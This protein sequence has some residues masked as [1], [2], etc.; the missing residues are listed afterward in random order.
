MLKPKVLRSGEKSEWE[1]LSSSLNTPPT[2]SLFEFIARCQHYNIPTRFLDFTTKFNIALYFA[3]ET[4]GDKDGKV[5][6]R[7]S[8]SRKPDWCDSLIISELC[9]LK[10]DISVSDF[11]KQLWNKY[12]DISK[13]YP[14]EEDLSTA[15]VSWLGYGFI[16]EPEDKDYQLFEKGNKRIMNQ[17]G[18]FWVS[19]NETSPALDS[20]HRRSSQAGKVIIKPQCKD[21]SNSIT[22]SNGNMTGLYDII[23]PKKLKGNIMM[24]LKEQ[25]ITDS[26]IYPD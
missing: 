13:K 18:V 1:H 15:M 19:G 4:E 12:V 24:L 6:I 20:F 8:D 10:D 3:C 26:F 22:E 21:L 7:R 25:Q 11:S 17:R 9:F 16:I 23:I 2:E 14:D 5:F